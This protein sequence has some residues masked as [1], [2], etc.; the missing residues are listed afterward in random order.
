[1]NKV[2]SPLAKY[3]TAVRGNR[4][5]KPAKVAV[6]ARHMSERVERFC[7]LLAEINREDVDACR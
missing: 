1:M 3:R 2:K 7:Q 4:G 5:S 6:P